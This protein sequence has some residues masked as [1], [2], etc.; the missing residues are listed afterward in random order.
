MISVTDVRLILF[1][2]A[3]TSPTA[4]SMKTGMTGERALKRS[5]LEKQILG[6]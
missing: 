1:Q 6:A 5:M 2:W 3:K 4:M